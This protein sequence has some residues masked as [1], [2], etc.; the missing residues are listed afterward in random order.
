M[1]QIKYITDELLN[2][3]SAKAKLSPRLRMN[4]NFHEDYADP[5]NRMLNALEPGTYCRPHKHEDPDKNEVFLVLKGKMAVLIFDEEGNVTETYTFAPAEGTHGIDIP[6]RIWHTLV[7]LEPGSV[8]YEIKDGPYVKPID[9]NFASW[10]PE[11]G[12]PEASSYLEKL[13]NH[14]NK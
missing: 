12:S 14:I 11:E 5:I 9:K 7:C 2:A 1:S 10:A 3:T 6:P 4:H 8:A 13:I